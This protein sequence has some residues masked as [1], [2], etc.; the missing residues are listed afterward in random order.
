M[1]KEFQKYGFKNQAMFW[2][3]MG[4][5][6]ETFQAIVNSE[7]W[8]IQKR[9]LRHK[10]CPDYIRDQFVK[11]KTWYKRFV[12]YYASNAPIK[13]RNMAMKDSDQRVRRP[14]LDEA[15]HELMKILNPLKVNKWLD[16]KKQ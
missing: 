16:K 15:Q 2:R 14:R 5:P 6:L 11:D 7:S 9:V 1:V 13:Y 8:D 3:T 10:E 4:I 12:A